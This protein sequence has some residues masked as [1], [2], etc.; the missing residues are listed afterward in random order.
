MAE[1]AAKAPPLLIDAMLGTLARRLRW[2]G[3]DAEYRN[4]LPDEEMIRIAREEGRLLVTRD[5]ALS[6]RR[7]VN[8]LYL[9]EEELEEQIRRVIEVVGPA[10]GEGR[11]TVCNGAL[12]SISREE[13]RPHV[14]PYVLRIHRRFM[15]CERCG[16][17]YWRGSHWRGMQSWSLDINTP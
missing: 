1:S 13:A 12:V 3:Y 7:G 9:A 5:R 14:P 2:L 15:R 16:R 10:S 17:V 11:C 8:A 4:D 6:R